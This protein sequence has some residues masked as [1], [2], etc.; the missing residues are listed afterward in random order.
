[1][2]DDLR[3]LDTPIFPE[4]V[5]YNMRRSFDVL[6]SNKKREIGLYLQVMEKY[7]LFTWANANS[8]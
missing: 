6:L 5:A 8:L 7:G 2:Q 3:Q 1:M 4:G